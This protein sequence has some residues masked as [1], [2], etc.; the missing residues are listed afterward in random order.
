MKIHRIKGQ[1]EERNYA[2]EKYKIRLHFQEHHH[3]SPGMPY[4]ANFM[5]ARY[6]GH[7]DSQNSLD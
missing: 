7:H 2:K 5:Q 1:E 4:R 6:D 3:A